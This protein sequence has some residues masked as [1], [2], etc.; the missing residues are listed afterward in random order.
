MG[1]VS[2]PPSDVL[3]S[4]GYMARSGYLL[5]NYMFTPPHRQ[6]G[7]LFKTI[8][9]PAAQ[10]TQ[11]LLRTNMVF[12]WLLGEYGPIDDF[13]ITK[14]HVEDMYDEVIGFPSSFTARELPNHRII[15]GKELKFWDH[16]LNGEKRKKP[17]KIPDPFKYP[18]MDEALDKYNRLSTKHLTYNAIDAKGEYLK[19]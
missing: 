12:N 8:A 15:I 1:K 6:H 5:P 2:S 14:S 19:K 4:L 18:V 10:N 9:N 13:T 17:L 11:E 16:I 7:Y 3:S